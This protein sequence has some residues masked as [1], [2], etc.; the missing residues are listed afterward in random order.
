MFTALLVDRQVTETRCPSFA[1]NAV[2][3]MN[4]SVQDAVNLGWKLALVERGISAPSLLSTYTEERLPVIAHMLKE[5]TQMFRSSAVSASGKVIENE[6]AWQRGIHM[7]QLGINYRWSSILLD[8]R[9]GPGEGTAEKQPLD[10]YGTDGGDT[11]RAG[12]RAPDAPGLVFTNGK[13]HESE[14]ISLFRIFGP[15]YH[16]VLVFTA[17]ASKALPVLGQLKDYPS[18]LI[19]PM[20]IFPKDIPDV[21]TIDN[22][23]LVLIDASGHASAGYAISGEDLVIVAVR[24]DGVIGCIVY[25]LFGLT[26]YFNTVFSATG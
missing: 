23:S 20:V 4:S 25:G 18:D 2:Q 7:K 16:T 8:E 11:V 10:A 6:A 17:S 5:T 9:A 19:R 1:D 15:S 21:P 3:G 26:T 22:V 12:D 13:D 24:P 14:S